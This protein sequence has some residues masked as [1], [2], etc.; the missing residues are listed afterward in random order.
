MIAESTKKTNAET[1]M[2]TRAR[3]TKKIPGLRSSHH[4]LRHQPGREVSRRRSMRASQPLIY[5]I[6]RDIIIWSEEKD[7]IEMCDRTFPCY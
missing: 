5:Q 2:I 7:L 4:R 6:W 3:T 1:T